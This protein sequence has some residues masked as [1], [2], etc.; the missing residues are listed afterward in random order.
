M[1]LPVDHVDSQRLRATI[2]AATSSGVVRRLP[3]LDFSA[4]ENIVSLPGILGRVTRIER[5]GRRVR[6]GLGPERALIAVLSR[7][8][9]LRPLGLRIGPLLRLLRRSARA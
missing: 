5:A 6:L 8:G 7:R 3:G 4:R 2:S 1:M 9:L